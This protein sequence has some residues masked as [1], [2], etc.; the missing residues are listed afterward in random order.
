MRTIIFPITFI[1]SLFEETLYGYLLQ[2]NL[3]SKE[4]VCQNAND[5]LKIL[6]IET[7]Q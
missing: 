5:I 7:P 1:L 6:Q 3:S 2:Q 4:R